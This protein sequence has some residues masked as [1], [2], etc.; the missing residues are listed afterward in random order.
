MA[1]ISGDRN[2][3][4]SDLP[5]MTSRIDQP[6]RP[7]R[8]TRVEAPQ[9]CSL[10]ERLYRQHAAQLRVWLG[11]RYPRADHGLVEDAVSESFAQ[12]LEHPAAFLRARDSGGDAGLRRLLR[13]VAWRN[14]RAH[15][16]KKARRWERTGVALAEPQDALTPQHIVSG[17]QTATR[18]LDLVDVAASR[19]GGGQ[20]EALRTALHERLTGG[21]DTEAARA[22]GVP[23]EYVNRAKRW[24]GTQLH[25]T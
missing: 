17:R 4:G 19:F 15:F 3:R 21:T 16:R 18:V 24:I 7:G 14:L 8:A 5:H 2:P 13:V 22:H 12:A 10:V 23:R 25:A 20:P 11:Q 6:L 9:Y 1:Q